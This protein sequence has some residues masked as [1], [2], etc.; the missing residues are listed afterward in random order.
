M[1]SSIRYRQLMI[2]TL[3]ARAPDEHLTPLPFLFALKNFYR[4]LPQ[5]GGEGR[6][7]RQILARRIHLPQNVFW[8]RFN[9]KA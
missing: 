6:G 4:R 7:R 5:T 1:N 8:R 3:K 2:A 9:E